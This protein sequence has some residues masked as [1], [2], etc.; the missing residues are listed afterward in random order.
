MT[1]SNVNIFSVTGLLCGEFPAQRP[2]TRSFDAF[3]DLRLNKQLSKQSWGWWFETLPRQLWCHSNDNLISFGRLF[4]ARGPDSAN[5]WLSNISCLNFGTIKTHTF[6]CNMLFLA[7]TISNIISETSRLIH[8]RQ[9]H[10][11]GSQLRGDL[12][13]DLVFHEKSYKTNLHL[14][15]T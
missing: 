6:L 7:V 1:S 11:Q 13:T 8:T 14:F 2:V 10:N 15:S 5:A 4:H 9:G 3:F 12:V